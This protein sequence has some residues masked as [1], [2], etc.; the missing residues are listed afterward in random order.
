MSIKNL[1][2][3]L[4][5]IKSTMEITTRYRNIPAAGYIFAGILGAAGAVA[6]FLIGLAE[7]QGAYRL[8]PEILLYLAVIWGCVLILAVCGAVVFSLMKAKKNGFSPWNSLA[9][10]MFFSQIPMA[11]VTA[12]LTAGCIAKG[13]VE[14]IPAIW[15]LSF[16]VVCHS[17]S[18]FTGNDHKIQGILFIAL[19]VWALFAPIN[20]SVILLGA[21]FGGV[22]LVFGFLRLFFDK[23]S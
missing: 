23:R 19:G 13:C 10:R 11:A 22:L 20:V 2:A 14:I 12:V 21:G 3:D 5:F 6:T 7:E 17:F 4:A 16:G 18:Y 8:K 15:L 9:A 1:E